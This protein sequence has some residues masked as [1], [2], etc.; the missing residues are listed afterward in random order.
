MTKLQITQKKYKLTSN[1]KTFLDK[2]LFQIQALTSFGNV[3]AGDLGGFIEKEDNLSHKDTAWVYGNARVSGTAWVSGNA[4]VYGTA[5]VSGNARIVWFTKV[6]REKG[7]LTAFMDKDNKITVTLGCYIGTLD[8]F[9]YKVKKIHGNSDIA[10]EY[11]L[12]IEFIKLRFKAHSGTNHS[13][14]LKQAHNMAQVYNSHNKLC[15]R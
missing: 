6:G 4:R 13:S 10:Q 1:T 15:V 8:E 3:S 2:K 7:T 14:K 9:A 11:E 12:L 5:R